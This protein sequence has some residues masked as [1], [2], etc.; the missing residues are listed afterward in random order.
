MKLSEES[1]TSSEKNMKNNYRLI[2]HIFPSYLI[3]T[4]VSLIAASWFMSGTIRDIF[5]ERTESS[6]KTQCLLLEKQIADNLDPLNMAAIDAECNKTGGNAQ[7]RITVVLSHGKVA[8][9]SEKNPS[10]MDNHLDRPE[11]VS[12][13]SKKTGRSIRYSSTLGKKMMYVAIPV[14]S[15]EGISAVI[16]ASLPITAVDKEIRRIQVGI[17]LGGLFIAVLATIVSYFISR[18]ITRPI[19]EMRLSS[20]KFAKGELG[21]RLPQPGTSE[22]DTLAKAMN[23]MAS[24][25]EIKIGSINTQRNEYEAVLSSMIEGVIALDTNENILNINQAAADIFNC[26]PNLKGVSIL[27]AVRNTELHSFL[28]DAI[29]NRKTKESDI[30]IFKN[31]EYIINIRSTLLYGS[32]KKPIGTLVVF[33]DVTTIRQLESMRR[34]FVGNVSHELKTP[35]TAI[36][37]FV[38]TLLNGA[39]E[40]IDDTKRFL[41]II[42]K[43]VNRLNLIIDDLLELSKIEQMDERSEINFI[44][45]RLKDVIENAVSLCREKANAKQIKIE[46]E[47]SEEI[48]A[49][50][51][52]YLLEQAFINLLDNA[53]K[54]SNSDSTI[55]INL[56]RVEN[57]IKINFK[58]RGHGIAKKH[59]DRLF[60]RFYR[61]DKARSRDAGGTGLGLAIVKHIIRAHGGHITVDSTVGKG[62]VFEI[63]LPV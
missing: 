46:P 8:G 59:I 45:T 44:E 11:I 62:S 29:V 18:R 17:A 20:E 30:K 14:L 6:L 3:I 61:V 39:V 47:Y 1:G 50:I 26:S 41:S 10:V 38:E 5:L 28:K 24:E 55:T 12:A 48:S 9:D 56:E 58:D 27:E 43:H 52:V 57:K 16:R 51:D 63:N 15:A 34:D 23:K 49:R 37:G 54:Y 4:I 21:H 32:N 2:W 35:L 60:E 7:T 25:L 19:E 22:L 13:F 33:N 36:K 40:N 31:K 42:E 53:I